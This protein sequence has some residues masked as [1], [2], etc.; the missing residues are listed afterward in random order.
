MSVILTEN[1][2]KRFGDRTAVVDL[3]LQVDSGT[4]FGFLGPNGA[5]KTTTIRMFLG[6]LRPTQG[7]SSIFGLDCW[8]QSDRVKAEVG[9]VP[10]DLR[11]YPW[12]TVKNGLNLVGRIRKRKIKETGYELAE[13]FK[14]DP[15]LPVRRMSR[16]TRQKLGLI[17]ALAHK[18]KVLILDEPTSALDPP[19]QE[20]LY[21]HLRGRAKDGAAVFFSSHTLS[22]V[23]SL[24]DR[25]GIL[26]DGRLVENERLEILR[27]RAERIVRLY[28]KP[29]ATPPVSALP[30]ALKLEKNDPAVWTCALVGDVQSA[31]RW[32]S[33]QPL[34][35]ITISPPDLDGLFRCY[36][37]EGSAP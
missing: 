23:E 35:N 2:T 34:E 27:H 6:L 16:G 32:S 11:L 5:G 29:N 24:C 10:G 1:A 30:P 7:H 4:I 9:Y 25:V 21:E 12:M 15:V 28:W 22:E 36:Y 14:L 19:M 20:A 13:R 8:T 31:L 33:E 26:R 37:Q 18:P 3:S 17:L